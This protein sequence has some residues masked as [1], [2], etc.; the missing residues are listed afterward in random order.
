MGTWTKK[1]RAIEKGEKFEREIVANQ[2]S[3]WQNGAAT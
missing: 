1:A 3:G 2:I